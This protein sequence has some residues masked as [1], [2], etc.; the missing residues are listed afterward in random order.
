MVTAKRKQRENRQV[1]KGESKDFNH[2][3]DRQSV[4]TFQ[5]S[6]SLCRKPNVST[7]LKGQ[8]T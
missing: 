7:A 2:L 3:P 6:Y 5:Q 4:V 8:V 1:K